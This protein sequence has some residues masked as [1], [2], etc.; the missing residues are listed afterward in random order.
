MKRGL[1]TAFD[2]PAS[3]VDAEAGIIRG[4]SVV[5]E[6]PAKGHGMFADRKTLETVQACAARYANG[7]RVKVEHEGTLLDTVGALRN[8]RIENAV[9]RADA[10]LMEADEGVRRKLLEMARTIPDT[11]GLS[12]DFDYTTE[13]V[14]GRK[15]ARCTNLLNVAL[16]EEPAANRSLFQSMENINEIVAA[17]VAEALKPMAAEMSAMKAKLEAMPPAPDT[18]PIEAETAALKAEVSGLR[19]ELSASKQEAIST[20]AAKLGVRDAAAATWSVSPANPANHAGDE[21]FAPLR[22]AFATARNAGKSTNLS[23]LE[24]RKAHPKLYDEFL[25]THRGDLSKLA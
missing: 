6:G 22:A 23:A 1:F 9:L 2:G 19:A 25:T 15:F 3:A 12:I 8:F 24:A 18:K 21:K 7:V 16:V 10:H 5:T 14:E 17:A 13:E 4:V 11:F 20:L